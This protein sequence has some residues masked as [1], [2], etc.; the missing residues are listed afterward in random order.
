MSFSSLGLS[1]ALLRAVRTLGY[2]APTAVQSAALP[3]AL[4]G[5]DVLALAQTGSG[6]TAA[7]ALPLLQR[8]VATPPR[9][10][11]RALVLA[12][13]REL[14]KQTAELLRELAATLLHRPK[15]ALAFGGVSINPQLMALRGGCDV[16]V[17]TP[18]RLLDLLDHNGLTLAGV[19]CLVLDEADRLLSQ[20]FADEL[21]RLLALLPAQRQSLLF[22]ATFPP[23]V[24]A[25]AA[26]LL[27]EPVCIRIEETPPQITQRAI[28]LDRAQ[29]L[30]ALRQLLKSEG[31]ARCLVFV[32]SRYTAEL[33]SDKL[34]AHGF[35]AGLLHGELSQG[36]RRDV[37]AALKAGSVEVLVATDVAARGLHVDALDAVVNYELPRSAADYTHR[38]GRTGRAGASGVAISFICADSAENAESHFRLIEKRQGQRVPRERLDGLE[39]QAVATEAQAT[40]GIKSTT[41]KSKK[42][43]LREAAAKAAGASQDGH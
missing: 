18:G 35:K 19:Q 21:Q 37:L 7:F 23:A 12:P 36:A 32:A 40:G 41:R 17:A 14:A 13:T 26:Q 9:P 10:G 6:K 33:V 15:V 38:I 25:L 5:A 34:F 3:P 28:Q 11:P 24:E 43:K 20:G 39:P 42:D 30:P 16:M 8:L 22:S 4:A 31:W 27:R 1:P 2:H 29:R